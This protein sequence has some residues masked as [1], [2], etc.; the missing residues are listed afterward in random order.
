MFL[1]LLTILVERVTSHGAL[2]IPTPRNAIDAS[3]PEFKGGK[4]PIEACTCNNGY[5]GHDATKTGCDMGLRGGFDG[6][7]DGQSCLWWSQGCSIGCKTCATETGEV[8][9]TGNPPQA[10]KIGF[11]KRYCDSTLEST[12]PREAWTLN[13]DVVEFSEEDS[14]RYN[15]WRAPG[16][17]PVVDACGQSGGEYAFQNIGGDS[18]YYNTT[19]GGKGKMGSTLPPTPREQR[20]VWTRGQAVEVAWGVRY[21]H[22]GGYSYRLCPANESLTEECFQRMPLDFDRSKQVL[23]WNDGSKTYEMGN[24][25]IFVDGNVTFPVG[26]TWA[27]N[28]IPRIFD[29]KIGLHDPESCPGPS[30][31]AAGSPKGCLAFPAPCPWD[32]YTTDGLLPCNQTMMSKDSRRGRELRCDGNGM[33]QC[34]SDWVVGVISDHVI[35]PETLPPG[36][37]VLGWRWDAEETAQ[38][39]SNCADVIISA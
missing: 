26:S 10:G 9:I 25:A 39:W 37:Y 3:L 34:S 17:A 35:I 24:Q 12:L 1:I 11:R 38:V 28:P 5:G 7:G 36:D 33:S 2:Y 20:P 31:R 19:N 29:S 16:R 6:Q 8:N 13:V 30:T 14:Y 4:S 18:V 15:P 27:R 32:T 21:N 23:K 22:G